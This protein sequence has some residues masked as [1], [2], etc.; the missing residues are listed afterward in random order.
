LNCDANLFSLHH[1]TVLTTVHEGVDMT[2]LL[3][4]VALILVLGCGLQ[5]AEAQSESAGGQAALEEIVV[6]AERR[7]TDL[8]ETPISITALTGEAL[9]ARAVTNLTEIAQFA[10]N[11]V[12]SSGTV[13]S[14][15][16]NYFIRGIGQQD[17]FSNVEPGVGVYLDGVYLGRTAGAA[18]DLVDLD[19]V[20]VLRG[21]Q[22]TLF[23]RNTIGGAINLTTAKPAGEFG[24]RVKVRAGENNRLDAGASLDLP[25][26]PGELLSRWSFVTRNRDG[27]AHIV[28]PAGERAGDDRVVAGRAAFAYTPT[29]NLSVDATFDATRRKGTAQCSYSVGFNPASAGVPAGAVDQASPPR[30]VCYSSVENNAARVETWGGAATAALNVGDITFKSITATRG[31]EQDASVDND[32]SNFNLYDLLIDKKQRQFS[33][34]LQAYGQ[35]FDGRL[36]WLL[37]GYFFREDIRE[38]QRLTFAVAGPNYFRLRKFAPATKSY[39]AFGQAT[40]ALSERWSVTGGLRWMNDDK[41]F[42]A[43]NRDERNDVS[44]TLV[45][46]T[47]QKSWS[48][49]TP[50]AGVEYRIN[51]DAMLYASYSEGFRGGGF[52]ARVRNIGQLVSFDPE[53]AKVYEVGAKTEAFE[54]RLRV[55]AAVFHTD[56]QDIQ[57]LA[58]QTG[59]FSNRNAG[60]ARLYG[61]ELEA[62]AK[63]IAALTLDLGAG[64]TDARY[65]RLV[66][67]TGLTT[68]S[69]LPYAPE[70]TFTAGAQFEQDLSSFGLLTARFDYAYKSSQNVFSPISL[71]PAYGIANARIAVR[72]AGGVEVAIYGRNLFDERYAVYRSVDLSG[73]PGS[74]GISN[75]FLGQPRELGGEIIVSF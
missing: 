59:F 42:R 58:L 67:G 12:A 39:A 38:Q 2:M 9:A 73:A 45:D 25:L 16:G 48:Q 50:K 28:G 4:R 7:E 21:P 15:D 62:S 51:P 36:N 72:T 23:G 32:G 44:T 71:E 37:G 20:E 74:L 49:L 52:N 47:A 46:T 70:W 63:P 1:V 19:R 41:D 53:T 61:F 33:E 75:E 64:Y 56:Y 54:R 3:Q 24:G 66:A 57:I 11:L 26:V 43:L 35:A 22:G 60:D 68:T 31:L 69:R 8:Q 17:A 5:N 10:P 18:L 29:A 65:S 30:D 55:N 40:F 13:S 14:N 27:D 6:T 34:E